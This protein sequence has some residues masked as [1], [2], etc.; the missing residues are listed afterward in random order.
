M[1]QIL[2]I[3]VIVLFWIVSFTLPSGWASAFE[4]S[5]KTNTIIVSIAVLFFLL[6]PEKRLE[7]SH[8]I[9]WWI[10]ISF[11]FIPVL[12]CGSMQGA[13]Y[14]VS[15]L[16]VY[17]VSQG[18]I[19]PKVVKY[20]AIIIALLGIFTLNIYIHGNLLSGW[21]DNAMSMVG[22]FSFIYFLIFLIQKKR[23]KIFWIWNIVTIIY[24]DLL[25]MTD[26]RS[27]MLFAIIA[28]VGIVFASKTYKILSK[29]KLRL[30]ILNAPLLLALLVIMIASTSYFDVLDKWSIEN[31]DKG[32]FDGREILW[33][34]S[35]DYLKSTYLL[36]TGKFVINYHN[37]GIA[38]ISVFGVIGYIFWIKFFSTNM[39]YMQ[40]YISDDIVF[41]C[42]LA[43]SIIFLQQAFDLGF[44]SETPNLL[45]Y[46]VLGVGLG[47][48]RLLKQM[49]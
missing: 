43:F 33:E 44:I 11:V 27:G 14:L 25:F 36:G 2:T 4:L 38:A 12:M 34:K 1:G 16:V 37:S 29:P 31:F 30:L 28:V 6:S 7:I 42:I 32:I 22:L 8:R 47:R 40:K 48:V 5:E 10:L 17:I 13:S 18:K 45:P 26:C 24:L 46:I 9:F 15:F 49:K 3:A 21:N 23:K 19:T 39:K 35:L 20:S 41:G